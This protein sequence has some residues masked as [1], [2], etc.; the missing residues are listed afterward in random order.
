MKKMLI[1]ICSGLLLLSVGASAQEQIEIYGATYFTPP[2]AVGTL[3]TVVAHLEPPVGFS[4]P[5]PVDFSTYEYTFYFQSTITSIITGMFSIDITYADGEFFIY[6]DAAKN[7]DYGTYPPNA[8]SPSTFMDGTLILKGTLFNI[9]RSDDP[10]GFLEPS[11][12]SECLFTGGTKLGEL[13]KPDEWTMHGGL[14]TDPE[15]YPEGYQQGWITKIF[16]TGTVDGDSSTWGAIKSL[17]AAE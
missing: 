12:I 17:Y 8:T 3:V 11:I 6:E 4:Y 10:F 16:F 15:I 13:V 1:V 2:E 5:F 14:S 9:Y 7:G